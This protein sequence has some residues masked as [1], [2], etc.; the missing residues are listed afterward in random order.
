MKEGRNVRTAA[1]VIM[2][3]FEAF[4]RKEWD[5]Y[6]ACFSEDVKLYAGLASLTLQARGR[7]RIKA[8]HQEFFDL[9]EDP[10]FQV[11][12]LT[13]QAKRAAVE[14]QWRVTEKATGRRLGVQRM[15]VFE[16]DAGYIQEVR[17]Y[18]L[19]GFEELP[20]PRRRRFQSLFELEL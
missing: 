4:I 9:Y 17:V 13:C 6:A 12:A 15:E 2:E 20:P 1:E 7:E 10:E 14:Y 3:H 16:V 8:L 18:S 5:R 11:T 19:P